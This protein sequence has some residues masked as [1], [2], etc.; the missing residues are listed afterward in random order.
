MTLSIRNLR[1]SFGKT[2]ILRGIDLDLE[3]GDCLA[4]VGESG[5]G[6]TTLGLSVMGLSRGSVSGEIRFKKRSLFGISAEEFREL[7]GREMA[8]VFQNVEDALDPVQKIADQI[9][10]A[11]K[12]HSSTSASDAS[13][14]AVR[15][16]SDVGL[17]KEKAGMYPHQ[18]S[19]GEKQRA[20]IAMALV[21]DPDLLILDEPL[22]LWT[23]S[24]RRISSSCF[25]LLL[26]EGCAWS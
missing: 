17:N 11:I 20:L 26:W 9:A 5:A 24:P 6:K 16:L 14:L 23:P 19:G 4:L 1:L 21:N 8:M 25:G 12:G 13:R 3:M 7:R 2:E 22:H 10:E 15:H 18:L